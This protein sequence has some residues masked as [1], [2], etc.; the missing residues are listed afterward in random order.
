MN[1]TGEGRAPLEGDDAMKS[2]SDTRLVQACLG[3]NE[4]AWAAI[5]RR[6]ERLI[7][8]I[9][10]KYRMEPEDA[11]DVFQA[12]CLE[13]F[14]QLANLRKTE[15][16]KSWLISVTAHKC[17]HWKKG[18]REDV[19]LDAMEQEQ[20]ESTAVV[21]PELL[22][23]VEQEQQLRDAMRQ[24]KPQCAELIRM[25]FYEQ[26][27]IPYAEVGRRL[28][29]ATGSIGF[30]RARCLEKLQKVLEGMGF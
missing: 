15:S 21:A 24:L 22:E 8:S 19:E 14:T 26:P 23:E 18:Q 27:P 9:P 25:L 28:G 17:Y 6:Y 16:L 7:Y 5:L 3:G 1:T 30:I 20:A 10:F 29:L 2:W 11:A 13:L 12:V 4:D